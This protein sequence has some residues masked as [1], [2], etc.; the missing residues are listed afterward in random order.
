MN[1]SQD[2]VLDDIKNVYQCTDLSA[3]VNSRILLTGGNGLLGSYFTHLFYFLNKEYSFNIKVDLV[4]R[5]IVSERS[6]IYLIK[7]DP[8]FH[9]IQS[10]VSQYTKYEEKYDYIIHAA[11]YSSP[12]IFLLD[13]VKVIDV[14]YIGLKSIVES[15]LKTNPQARIM[16][17]SSSE[18]YGSP[19]IFPT[20]E[21][22]FG[23]SSV[24]NNRACYIESKRL[25]EVLAL[26]Y[27]KLYDMNIKIVRPALS[28]GPGMNFADQRV[29]SNFINKAHNDK[30]IKM[31]DD[32]R[33]LRCFCYLSDVLR[34][35]INV[36]LFAKDTIY[37]IGSSNEEIS[38]KDLAL[39]IGNLMGVSVKLGPGKTSVVVGAPSRVCLDT[40]K[41]ERE[42]GFKPEV[43]MKDGLKR[44]ID[45]NLL[46]ID[47]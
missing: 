35:L 25:S 41:I 10:D 26:N 24:E 11:G 12:S 20:S 16:Y 38:V 8:N 21:T 30:V 47:K 33:D 17:F 40:S 14:N 34:Q 46:N 31:I 28:Y 13:P 22:Y 18:I 7:D 15:C 39:M 27:N 42:F 29:I 36:L 2:I 9:I 43:T 37:N 5:S 45:W 3:L 19:T 32:G 1:S 4:T 23:N 6:R 44:T